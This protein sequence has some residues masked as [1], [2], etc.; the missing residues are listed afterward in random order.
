[1]LIRRLESLLDFFQ[2]LQANESESSGCNQAIF[3]ITDGSPYPHEELFNEYKAKNPMHPVRMFTYL[4]GKEVTDV[5]HVRWM[6]CGNQGICLLILFY[7]IC[8]VLKG[9]QYCC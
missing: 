2:T 1:M 9:E 6:A 8:N 7:I 3:L 5:R 4:I